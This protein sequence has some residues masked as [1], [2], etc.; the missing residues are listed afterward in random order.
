[1]TKDQETEKL[2]ARVEEL[3]NLLGKIIVTRVLSESP[4]AENEVQQLLEK[5]WKLAH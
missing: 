4:I 5:D 1:M 3:E 2:R